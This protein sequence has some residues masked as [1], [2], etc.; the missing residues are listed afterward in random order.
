MQPFTALL[1]KFKL[2]EKFYINLDH[3]KKRKNEKTIGDCM[4][5]RVCFW[6]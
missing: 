2:S 1:K 3:Q 5:V 6:L 4:F